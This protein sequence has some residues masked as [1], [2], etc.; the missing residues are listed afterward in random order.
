[1]FTN[2]C[3]A[4]YIGTATDFSIAEYS[5]MT[6]DFSITIDF[7]SV[8]YCSIVR[9]SCIAIDAGITIYC[10]L[11]HDLSIVINSSIIPDFSSVIN[12][13]ISFMG[14]I[15][16]ILN[17][18]TEISFLHCV[19]ILAGTDSPQTLVFLFIKNVLLSFLFCTV[20]FFLLKIVIIMP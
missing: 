13:T 3:C 11:F 14:K 1:M 6:I 17:K 8:I 20:K 12:P 16:F 9:N 5:C 15:V 4:R 10:S 2:F 7:G 19:E 18:S